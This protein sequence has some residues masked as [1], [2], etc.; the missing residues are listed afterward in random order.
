M[1]AED[2]AGVVIVNFRVDKKSA[3]EV[4]PTK[5]IVALTWKPLIHFSKRKKE[6]L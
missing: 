1:I 6:N 4:D 2:E 3:A 5:G